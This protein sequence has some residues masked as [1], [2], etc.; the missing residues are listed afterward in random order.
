M[1][2]LCACFIQLG[3]STAEDD[4]S[5]ST[6]GPDLTFTSIAWSPGSPVVGN[7][8]AVTVVVYNAGTDASTL[9]TYSYTFQGETYTGSLPVIASGGSTTLSFSVQS[10]V[11]GASSLNVVLDPSDY[12]TETD[13]TN[14][15]R[16]RTISWTQDPVG[17]LIVRNLAPARIAAVMQPKVDGAWILHSLTRKLPIRHFVVYS[18]IASLIGNPGQTAYVAAN[19]FL[20]TLCETR[21]RLG[22]P[23]T[24]MCWGPIAD[25]GVFAR[26]VAA[27]GHQRL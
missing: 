7:A 16:A 23:G 11:Y 20:E 19:A 14:N 24:A 21:R 25:T 8:T 3:C 26:A 9:T 22:L 27:G 5:T 4:S 10:N 13:E 15:S 17:D 12:V 2:C 1:A 18:S 6:T